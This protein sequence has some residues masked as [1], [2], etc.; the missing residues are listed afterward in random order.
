MLFLVEASTAAGVV[1]SLFRWNVRS[2]TL[3]LWSDVSEESDLYVKLGL[4]K[5]SKPCKHYFV[6]S[7]HTIMLKT[8]KSRLR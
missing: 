4:T 8:S 1:F 3:R 7:E 5:L 2:E 6:Y